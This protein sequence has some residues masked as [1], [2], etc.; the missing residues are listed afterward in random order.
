MTAS[1][2]IAVSS[3]TGDLKPK[4]QASLLLELSILYIRSDNM[5]KCV[6]YNFP[7]RYSSTIISITVSIPVPAVINGFPKGERDLVLENVHGRL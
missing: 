4:G 2:H 1:R 6:V 3:Y 5:L 7:Y